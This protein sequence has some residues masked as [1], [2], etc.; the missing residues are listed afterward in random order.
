MDDQNKNLLLAT[1]LSFLVLL[2]WMLMFPPE[3]IE[4]L[5]PEQKTE[6]VT[7]EDNQAG[8]GLSTPVQV[9][10]NQS[11]QKV[12]TSADAPRVPIETSRL[13][14]SLSL[15]GGKIDNLK[16]LDYFETQEENSKN[17]EL[18]QYENENYYAV[19]GWSSRDR[20]NVPNPNTVWNLAKGKI[21]T[22]R[23]PVTLQW[24]SPRVVIFEREISIDEDF[25]V[26]IKQRVFNQSNATIDLA[27][28]GIL[29]RHSAPETIGF[30]ILHEGIV[31]Y[32]LSLIHI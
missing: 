6:Q 13:S 22:P 7:Q 8:T 21:L 5:N 18:F 17:I 14:G 25:L 4:E 11:Q 30:Y 20:E 24:T 28:Y 27:A 9:D 32:D 12:D 2:G 16:L 15:K 26:T 31:G 29:A 19:Y 23:T 3:P 10:T 1:S